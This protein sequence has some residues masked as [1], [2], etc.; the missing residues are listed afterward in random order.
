MTLL[1]V[2]T[3]PDQNH[4]AIMGGQWKKMASY[5]EKDQLFGDVMLVDES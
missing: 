2:L 3:A 1:L 5:A 4:L